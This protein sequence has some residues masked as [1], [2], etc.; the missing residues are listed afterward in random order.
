MQKPTVAYVYKV[1]DSNILGDMFETHLIRTVYCVKDHRKRR[2]WW[3]F[4]LPRKR[5]FWC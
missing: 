3:C 5:L 2:L 1:S 4:N